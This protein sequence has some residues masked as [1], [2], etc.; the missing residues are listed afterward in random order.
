MQ[1]IVAIFNNQLAIAAYLSWFEEQLQ[2]ELFDIG[3]GEDLQNILE[4]IAEQGPELTEP[5]FDEKGNSFLIS[6]TIDP[7]DKRYMSAITEQLNL[8]GIA[9]FEIDPNLKE[10][11]LM[12]SASKVPYDKRRDIL[13]DIINMSPEHVLQMNDAVGELQKILDL[14]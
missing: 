4:A 3:F 6:Y 11:L 9:S 1:K 5:T 8:A 14:P 13:G 7:G 2:I 10:A 12:L